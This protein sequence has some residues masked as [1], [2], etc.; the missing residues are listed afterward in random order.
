M[1]EIRI[2]APVDPKVLRYFFV[3]TGRDGFMIKIDGET[4]DSDAIYFQDRRT[5]VSWVNRLIDQVG[6]VDTEDIESFDDW[7]ERDFDG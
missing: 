2:H 7:L 1:S 5:L 3:E 4:R 6:G